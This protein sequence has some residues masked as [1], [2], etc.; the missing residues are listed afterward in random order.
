MAVS[1]YGR[2]E[3]ASGFFL[4]S[5]NPVGEYAAFLETRGI[6]L[7]EHKEYAR[8]LEVFNHVRRLIPEHPYIKRL[9]DDAAF[10][11]LGMT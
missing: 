1:A 11:K 6:C 4:K 8:A 10:K 2:E 3:L 7:L 9:I 5:M